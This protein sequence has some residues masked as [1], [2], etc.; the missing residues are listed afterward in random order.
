[1]RFKTV[2][3]Q[4][5]EEPFSLEI[6]NN[7]VSIAKKVK[8]AKERLKKL[9]EGSSRIVFD[10]NDKSVLKLAKNSKGIGQNESDGDYGKH[11]MYPDLIPEV[12]DK[13]DDGNWIIVAKA[14]KINTTKFKQLTKIDFQTFSKIVREL[15]LRNQGKLKSLSAE[16][17][18]YIDDEDNIIYGVYDLMGNFN[19]L[20]GDI[21]KINSWGE[22]K[23]KA[24]LLDSGLTD[25]VYKTHYRKN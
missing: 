11:R 16:A 7:F 15:E 17:Q 9:G 20:S 6:L 3:L 19:L 23:N 1:M 18:N 22:I 13:D 21:T 4:E 5:N 8:Y 10:Y 24:V 12:F 25:D 2:Y 14:N